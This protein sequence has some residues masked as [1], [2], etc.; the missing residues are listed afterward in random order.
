MMAMKSQNLALTTGLDAVLA[1]CSFS[2]G[3]TPER[4]GEVLI[5]GAPGEQVGLVFVDAD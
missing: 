4:A 5:E 2:T 1:S 3:T